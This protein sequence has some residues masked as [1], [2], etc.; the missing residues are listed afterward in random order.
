MK[1]VKYK[2]FGYYIKYCPLVLADILRSPLLYINIQ[3]FFI[4]IF[5]KYY[6]S[7]NIPSTLC[8]MP[9]LGRSSGI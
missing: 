4:N 1:N 2:L 5:S 9:T 3:I 8:Y 7:P 6:T